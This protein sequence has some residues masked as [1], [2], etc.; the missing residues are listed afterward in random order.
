MLQVYVEDPHY[1]VCR[2]GTWAIG[3][4]AGLIDWLLPGEG[5]GNI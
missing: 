3:G 4:K 2:V 1:L 5:T